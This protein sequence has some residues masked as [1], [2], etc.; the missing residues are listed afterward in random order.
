M[1]I[2]RKYEW[3]GVLY[4]N[5]PLSRQAVDEALAC[6]NVKEDWKKELLEYN[7]SRIPA[8]FDMGCGFPSNSYVSFM[9]A[10]ERL[11]KTNPYDNGMTFKDVNSVEFE[12]SRKG[13][14]IQFRLISKLWDSPRRIIGFVSVENNDAVLKLIEGWA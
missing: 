4:E 7:Y 2:K 11:D 5:D 9:E 3:L 6:E 8:V 10:F 13:T 14:A 1:I 12:T